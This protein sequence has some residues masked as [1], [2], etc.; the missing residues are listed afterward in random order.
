MKAARL[1]GV[2]DLRV[3]DTEKP[4]SDHHSAVVK[5]ASCV[6]CG[7]DVHQWDGRH[8]P[9]AYPSDFGHETAGMV[10]EVGSEVRGLSVSDR[11]TWYL[12]HGSLAEYFAFAPHEMAVGKLAAHITWEEGATI[13]L[14]CA[15]M[16]GVVNGK[17]GPGKRALVLGCGAVGLSV[18]Q[19]AR[20]MG[21]D[22]VIAADLIPFRRSLACQLGASYTV[23]PSVEGWYN[24]LSRA[25]ERFHIVYDCMDED[26]SPGGDTLDL[27]LR[28][29]DDRGRCVIV[30]IS[31]RPRTIHTHTILYRGLK[32]IGAHHQEMARVRE[33]MA[34]AC[35][36]VAD[37]TV[38]VKPYVTHRFPLAEAQ[39]AVETAAAQ[40]DGVLKVA[41]N[42]E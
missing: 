22:E 31:S 8:P 18:L 34:M 29:M 38:S 24:T 4:S 15:V 3:V 16:R 1:F 6:L 28:L 42:L 14:L 20:A 36:W 9:S 21:M 12:A 5:V 11:V 37:G 2:R 39:K 30:G 35:Q 7:S 23:D 17:P 13:Q 27:A 40:A 32:I 41:V 25:G 10:V 33:L 19:C 26:R